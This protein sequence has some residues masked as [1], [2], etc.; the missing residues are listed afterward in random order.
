M[1]QALPAP[2]LLRR[3]AAMSYDTLLV[4]ALFFAATGLYQ[5]G[6]QLLGLGT[7]SATVS[8]GEVITEL[9]PVASGIVFRLYLV[10]VML[11][12]FVWFWRNNGQTL[13]M[14][15]WRLRLDDVEGGRISYGKAI[16]RFAFAWLSALCF[17]LGYLWVLVDKDK[18]SWHDR[19]SGS[20][21]VQL[22]KP[23]R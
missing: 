3:L 7:V 12:F 14:Q 1:E 18:C 4:F 6:A 21:V 11:V 19:L 23:G 16:L 2:G 9:E 10:L 15:V 17:G 22:P 13:G 5:Y 8:T 20:R